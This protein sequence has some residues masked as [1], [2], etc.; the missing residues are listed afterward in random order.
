MAF[1]Q[2]LDQTTVEEFKVGRPV[3]GASTIT[4]GTD[5]AGTQALIGMVVP[6]AGF[7]FEPLS[8][9]SDGT[10]VIQGPQG[11]S[12]TPE[13]LDFTIATGQGYWDGSTP[14]HGQNL[15]I[16]T[17]IGRDTAPG[18]KIHLLT[19]TSNN[20]SADPEYLTG[21]IVLSANTVSITTKD[22]GIVDQTKVWSWVPSIGGTPSTGGVELQ[23][24]GSPGTAGQ[25]LTS[26]GAGA[27]PTWETGSGGGGSPAGSDTQIQF[28]NAGA[29]GADSAFTY[30]AP[31]Q[32]LSVGGL[33]P[34][35]VLFD[36][37]TD[38]A[39]SIKLKTGDGG[40][41]LT[42]SQLDLGAGGTSAG[43]AFTS[44]MGPD[45]ISASQFIINEVN[46]SNGGDIQFSAGVGGS[47]G[48]SILFYPGGGTNPG[49]I[50][51]NSVLGNALTIDVDGA[52]RVGS[53]NDPGTS[54][55]VLTSNGSGAEPTWAVVPW[56]APTIDSATATTTSVTVDVTGKD[57]FRLLLES[58]VTA[59]TLTG[60]V[61]GQKVNLEVT[62]DAVG[63]RLITWPSN[64]RYGT[65]LTSLT[66]TT[67]ANKMDRV[68]LI[69]NA[70][71]SK[72]DVVAFVKGF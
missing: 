18:G 33:L 38:G 4:L 65:D 51:L 14:V 29:F 52:F 10:T 13:P 67:T 68:G 1:R 25:V 62:Q 44:A 69:Y 43:V 5:E 49:Q 53:A 40:F 24:N 47:G 66:L 21:D 7:T 11:T 28:N 8:I 59:L 31:T 56:Q 54:G 72:Y 48:G 19:G 22:T 2:K 3:P 27:T 71:A 15:V 57:T 34:E 61:D 23:L 58:S 60:A 42:G 63:S 64:V 41:G 12:I 6:A 20:G 16:Q 46:T 70:A 37:N 36:T 30:Y 32:R 9:S 35:Q 26:A 45:A 39:G 55:Q 17:G 50:V